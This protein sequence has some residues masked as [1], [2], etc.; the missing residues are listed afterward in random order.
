MAPLRTVARSF[1]GGVR[2]ATLTAPERKRD[3]FRQRAG[4]WALG[5]LAFE[6]ARS[7]IQTSMRL[8]QRFI[9]VKL[10]SFTKAIDDA[11]CCRSDLERCERTA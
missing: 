1:E 4:S 11:P 10:A 6:R 5:Y 2:G 9:A 8:A 7:A 3:P